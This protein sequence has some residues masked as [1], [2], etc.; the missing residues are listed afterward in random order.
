MP[1]SHVKKK[2][3]K[4]LYLAL[5][6]LAVGI[7]AMGVLMKKSDPVSDKTHTT[8][9]LLQHHSLSNPIP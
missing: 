8:P 6:A 3:K 5:G 7:T 2:S 1:T 4:R 9:P